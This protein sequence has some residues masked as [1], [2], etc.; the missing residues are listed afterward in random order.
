MMIAPAENCV[1]L[2]HRPQLGT[3]PRHVRMCCR[4]FPSL[5]KSCL[6]R[7]HDRLFPRLGSLMERAR[8][9]QDRQQL[10]ELLGPPRYALPGE[11]Y[12]V[13]E[14]SP[15]LVECYSRDGCHIDV[16]FRDGGRWEQVGL[17]TPCA[18]DIGMSE[19]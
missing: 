19:R 6:S 18:W 9:C 2:N 8:R 13:G 3:V 12:K 14:E 17:V 4:L 7:R 5:V 16:L 11:S 15:D 10:E 1:L